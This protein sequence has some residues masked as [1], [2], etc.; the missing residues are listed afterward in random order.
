MILI[1]SR[2]CGK[3][4]YVVGNSMPARTST[5]ITPSPLEDAM[6]SRLG[7]KTTRLEEDLLWI[8]WRRWPI[9]AS[10]I[11]ISV[12]VARAKG[13]ASHDKSMTMMSSQGPSSLSM[14][15]LS[16]QTRIASSV[17]IRIRDSSGVGRIEWGMK[18]RGNDL[19][20]TLFESA[21]AS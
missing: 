15:C 11:W 1:S 6:N 8:T 14:N 18:G 17:R 10:H 19:M 9:R 21:D 13:D 2:C 3:N 20:V 16:D 7:E 12:R 5:T 4:K